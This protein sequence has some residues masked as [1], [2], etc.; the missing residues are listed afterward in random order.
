MLSTN[1]LDFENPVGT[2]D[3]PLIIT[4]AGQS[5]LSWTIDSGQLPSWLA[6]G[7]TSGSVDCDPT[8]DDGNPNDNVN[9][10]NISVDRSGLPAGD[11]NFDMAVTGSY[12]DNRG[13]DFELSGLVTV[14]MTVPVP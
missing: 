5:S 11:Y 8:L 10:I 6:A 7:K 4:N 14:T 3:L 13:Q 1:N 2:T 12:T 9:T